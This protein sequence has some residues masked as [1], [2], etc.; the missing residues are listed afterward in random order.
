MLAQDSMALRQ[1]INSV[2]PDITLKQEID[3]EGDSVE[4]AIPMAVTFFWPETAG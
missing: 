2:S 1:K 4:V 3:I